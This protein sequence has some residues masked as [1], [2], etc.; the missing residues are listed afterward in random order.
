MDIGKE[1]LG[2]NG[3]THHSLGPRYRHRISV[4]AKPDLHRQAQVPTGA[5]LHS[6]IQLD[7][8]RHPTGVANMDSGQHT[9]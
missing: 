6:E 3:G 8:D 2:V 5:V 4:T 9:R 7:R 1:I